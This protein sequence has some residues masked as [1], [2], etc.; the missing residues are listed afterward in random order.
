MN[1]YHEFYRATS[2]H[3]GI[4]LYI[5]TLWNTTIAIIQTLMQHY[6]GANFGQ[7]CIQQFFS[8]IVY[9]TLFCALETIVL[10]AV[11]GT[12]IGTLLLF[13]LLFFI[14]VTLLFF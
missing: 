2:V 7:Y 1:G 8:P 5:V 9:V 6:Y 11:N 14:F 13:L 4:P 3:K 10:S 12:Y